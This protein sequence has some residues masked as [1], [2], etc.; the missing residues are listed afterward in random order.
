MA[1]P[2][3]DAIENLSHF[4]REHE[5]FYAQQPRQ[6]AVNLQR[7]SRTL[8]A[9][10]DRWSTVTVEALDA[11]NPYEGSP[12]LNSTDATQLDGVLFMEGEGE[13]VEMTRIKRDLRT[14]GDDSIETGTAS[15]PTTGT[16]PP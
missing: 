8:C 12:D 2:L 11:L 6:Q 1:D 10:A 14:I 16:P 9:L 15:S 4:H 7:H 13:P 5:K 3:L